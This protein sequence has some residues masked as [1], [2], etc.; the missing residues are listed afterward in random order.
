MVQPSARQRPS[1][2]RIARRDDEVGVGELGRAEVG[3]QLLEAQRHHDRG[4][5]PAVLGQV[6]GVEVLEER[7]EGV[8][9]APV[10]RDPFAGR[11]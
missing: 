11:A 4:R 6:V 10:L 9:V 1:R 3:A 2:S 5:V 7:H 8:G